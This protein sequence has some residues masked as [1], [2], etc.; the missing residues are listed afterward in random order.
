MFDLP[1]YKLILTALLIA[2]GCNFQLSYQYT[3][4]NTAYEVFQKYL[5]QT[6]F[7]KHGE[8]L[9]ESRYGLLWGTAVNSFNIGQ[10]PGTL[11][12]PILAE[13]FG[14]KGGIL[15]SNLFSVLGTILMCLW[16]VTNH[17]ELLSIGRF[18]IGIHAGI[19]NGMQ[20]L[21]L[22]EISPVRFRGLFGS[23]QELFIVLTV[24][25]GSVIGLPEVLGSDTFFIHLLVLGAIPSV[26]QT[27]I[28]GFLP[29]SP[30]HLLIT[31]KKEAEAERSLKFYYG[32]DVKLETI[33]LEFLEENVEN[34][35][36]SQVFTLSRW[37]LPSEAKKA[38]GIAAVAATS[39]I[40]TGVIAMLNYSNFMFVEAGLDHSE[41]QN[42]TVALTVTNF[43]FGIL[44][45]CYIEK[46]GRKTLL[47][48]SLIG[49]AATNIFYCA[50]VVIF[51]QFGALKPRWCSYVATGSIFLHTIMFS[52]GA[53]PIPFFLA[54]EMVPQEHRS[55]AQTITVFIMS[56]LE[57]ATGFL[58]YPLYQ[59]VV[60]PYSIVIVYVI[61]SIVCITILLL[62]MPETKGRQIQEIV[63]E[64][65][66]EIGLQQRCKNLCSR[67]RKPSVS[68]QTPLLLNNSM[69]NYD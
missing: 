4:I 17:Y 44:A 28:L 65:K 1:H 63:N 42:A 23:F 48:V 8:S 46:I 2:I 37:K 69:K 27:I 52:V 31:L 64:L 25:A 51:Q 7:N 50:F 36:L 32:D 18:I 13:K 15:F 19:C 22:T 30:K 20:S 6:Y 11:L 24:I 40:L 33:K 57:V 61:P 66:G 35:D 47:L 45:L 41:S 55:I 3:V 62:Y 9:T 21:Y 54:A 59:T 43:V 38:I 29:E 16:P 58:F 14:R 60:G 67:R 39:Q 56:M 26:V 10:L 53:G 68:D 49:S 34:A 12:V 5:N